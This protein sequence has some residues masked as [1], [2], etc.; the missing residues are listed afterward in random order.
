M[1]VRPVSRR[2]LRVAE[3]TAASAADIRSSAIDL[4][5]RREHSYQELIDKLSRRYTDDQLLRQEL[6]K[7]AE[8]KLQSDSRYCEV[9]VRSR[10]RRGYGPRRISQE[11]RQR[12]V[13]DQLIQEQVWQEQNNWLSVLQ[14]LYQK[15]YGDR[16][17]L[18]SKDKAK[19]VRFLQS[20]GFD[21]DMIRDVTCP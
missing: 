4:L 15:R 1:P 8:D 10:R 14:E 20:R 11:L 2:Y 21:F 19:R 18:D 13:C 12:R 5:A 16:L 9:Y 6:D 3:A 17:P 7:L